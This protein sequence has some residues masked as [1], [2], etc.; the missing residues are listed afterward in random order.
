MKKVT[1]IDY[2]MGNLRSVAKAFEFVGSKVCVSNKREDLQAADFIVLPG[3]GA[4]A[5]GIN[6]LKTLGIIDILKEEVIEKK[7]LFLGICLGM[8]LLARES[9]EDGIHQGL[10][11]VQATVKKFDKNKKIR[12]PHMGWNEVQT[13]KD[14]ILF[15]DIGERPVFY[16]IHSYHLVCDDEGITTATCEYGEKFPAVI[17]KDNIFATQFHPEKSQKEGLQLLQ[18]FVNIPES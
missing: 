2:M 12:I 4:F 6:N 9:H 16:F 17:Q 5:K 14:N 3:V 18:N 8:Q 1:I 10:N 15:S 13:T 7:K 11:W